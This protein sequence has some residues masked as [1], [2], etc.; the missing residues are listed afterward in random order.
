M[1]FTGGTWMGGICHI[2]PAEIVKTIPIILLP[3]GEIG[4]NNLHAPGCS[5]ILMAVDRAWHPLM[6]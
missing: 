3:A 4:I 1:L 2:S 5:G 6:L